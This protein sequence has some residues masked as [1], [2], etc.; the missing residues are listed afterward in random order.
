MRYHA[1]R[2]MSE[3]CERERRIKYVGHDPFP[4]WHI[5]RAHRLFGLHDSVPALGHLT[6]ELVGDRLK[7]SFAL[8][9]RLQYPF[10]FK[11]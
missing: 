6:E 10:G 11:S 1:D 7:R 9:E 5:N 8:G 2:A 4:R 3:Y